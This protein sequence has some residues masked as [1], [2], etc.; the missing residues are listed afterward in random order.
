MKD[1]NPYRT[2]K[3][4]AICA[5]RTEKT[6]IKQKGKTTYISCPVSQTY[7]SITIAVYYP[8]GVKKRFLRQTSVH[9]HLLST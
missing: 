9:I 6:A 8:L 3:V 7:L 1:I 2:E 4:R 5:H